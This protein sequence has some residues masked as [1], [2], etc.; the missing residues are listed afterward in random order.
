MTKGLNTADDLADRAAFACQSFY[1]AVMTDR[2]GYILRVGQEFFGNGLVEA[3]FLDRHFHV[4]CENDHGA[5]Q[6]KQ[7]VNF[8]LSALCLLFRVADEG[9]KTGKDEWSC[10]AAKLSRERTHALGFPDSRRQV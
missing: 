5:L 7:R 1:R 10:N 8:L 6:I 9:D 3:E 2:K 4:P